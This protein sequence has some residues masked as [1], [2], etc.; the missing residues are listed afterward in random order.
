MW[1]DDAI[2][3]AYTN[4]KNSHDSEELDKVLGLLV[5]QVSPA[6]PSALNSFLPFL[7]GKVSALPVS[8]YILHAG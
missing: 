2:F 3:A 8:I 5:C 4:K 1:A 7:S 6:I